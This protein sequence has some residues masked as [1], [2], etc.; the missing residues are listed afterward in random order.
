VGT[1]AFEAVTYG[2]AYGF[3]YLGA[4]AQLLLDNVGKGMIEFTREES[5]LTLPNDLQ[6][7]LNAL[8]AFMSEGGL[9]DNISVR[10]SDSEV[11]VDFRNSRYLP[12]LKRLLGEGRE[13]VSCPFTLAARSV[14]KSMRKDIGEMN[15]DITDDIVRLTM[16][17]RDVNERE[18]DEENVSALMEQA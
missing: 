8:A 7:A 17:T 11:Q 4:Q 3:D 12:V 1:P 6:E 15:W 5:N 16:T 9:A 14:I 2:L 10:V 18:F 13:L